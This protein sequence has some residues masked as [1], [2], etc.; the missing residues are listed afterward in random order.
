MVTLLEMYKKI[1]ARLNKDIPDN[2][3]KFD[4]QLED[5]GLIANMCTIYFMVTGSRPSLADIK[6]FAKYHDSDIN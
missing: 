6:E 5:L 2:E 4:A 3:P 1:N